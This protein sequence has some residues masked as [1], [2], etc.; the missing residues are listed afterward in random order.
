MDEVN[1]GSSQTLFVA[2]YNTARL[3][4]V[5]CAHPALLLRGSMHRCDNPFHDA[6]E[7]EAG[8]IALITV[9]RR[10]AA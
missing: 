7:A 8:L 2:R 3:V 9:S 10:G 6:Q 4:P 1:L 5:P